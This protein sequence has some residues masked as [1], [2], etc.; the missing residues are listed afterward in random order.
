M[1][2]FNNNIGVMC[3]PPTG[4]VSWDFPTQEYS[5]AL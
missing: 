2:F 3:G 1:E 5:V 4:E